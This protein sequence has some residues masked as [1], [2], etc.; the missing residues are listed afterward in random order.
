MGR[1]FSH[2]FGEPAHCF[3]LQHVDS[4]LETYQLM[5]RFLFSE[6][7]YS[8]QSSH[9]AVNHVKRMIRDR[10]GADVPDAFVHLPERLGG[11]GLRNPFVPILTIRESIAKKSPA[12]IIQ[13]F[14]DAEKERYKRYNKQ[15]DSLPSVESRLDGAVRATWSGE[16]VSPETFKNLLSTDELENFFG[17]NEYTKHR[18]LTS[19]ALWQAYLSLQSLP[20]A[21]SPD[22]D[23]DVSQ[24]ISQELGVSA[25]DAGSKIQEA[26]W[27]LQMYRDGLRRDYGGLRLI[28]KEH[29]PLGVL[30]LL[31]SRAVT[32]TMV[33]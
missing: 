11:L 32:W 14:L 12:S 28:D 30:T 21:V 10:F 15:F 31:R 13:E 4:I 29:L 8:S 26:R 22:M 1:F 27:A 33:L 25:D 20:S 7:S 24:T 9:G 6:G 18:E 17:M 16:T 5:Q 3:G 23:S 19:H 2:T